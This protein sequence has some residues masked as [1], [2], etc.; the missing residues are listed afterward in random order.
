MR[1]R[2][3]AGL[4][5]TTPA[6]LPR[7]KQKNLTTT[8][9]TTKTHKT[10]THNHT[11][12]SVSMEDREG[13]VAAVSAQLER[14]LSLV[15]CT[16]VEDKL[17]D[18]VP[19]C[20]EQLAMAGV[21]VWVLTGDKVETAVSIA[22]SCRLFDASMAVVELREREVEAEAARRR[23]ARSLAAAA[24]RRTGGGGGGGTAGGANGSGSGG[25]GGGAADPPLT[26][27]NYSPTKL[28][29]LLWSLLPA[30]SAA[31]RRAGGP[32]VG[33]NGGT[34][35]G[36]SR[37][38]SAAANAASSASGAS[39]ASAAAAVA[40]DD[41]EDAEAAAIEAA[42]RSGGHTA[43]GGDQ[44]EQREE[45]DA[46]VLAAATNAML[47]RKLAEV[48]AAAAAIAHSSSSSE[49]AAHGVGHSGSAA[50]NVGLVIEGGALHDALAPR[51]RAS[52]LALCSS[53]RA[54]VF[55]RVSPIQKAQVVKLVRRGAGAIT[56]GIGDGANDVGMIRA[57]HIGVGISGREGRAAVLSSDFSFAQFRF[58]ARLLLVHGRQAYHRNSQ[59]VVYSFYK[60]WA[61]CLVFI[62][63]QFV[64]GE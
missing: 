1:A 63:L 25:S 12:A 34:S 47:A 5:T 42:A 32:S 48:R 19:E 38:S 29:R 58:L 39:S 26:P 37:P 2:E 20:L 18:G 11:A 8:T 31:K 46:A 4:T 49:A 33:G 35:G 22:H 28:Q 9:T 53:A 7:R 54:V 60:N 51:C 57:A 56:L 62:F 23:E 55:C 15:G 17:Q 10:T 21:K 59:V 61:Y 40:V 52:L 45:E 16:A 13:R 14:G 50:G 43:E 6:R 64:A 36:A 44:G 3:G 41:E 30:S 27:P 24:K